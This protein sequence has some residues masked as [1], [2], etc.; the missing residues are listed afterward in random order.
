MCNEEVHGNV[1]TVGDPVHPLPHFLWHPVGVEVQVD[2][3]GKQNYLSQHVL[4]TQGEDAREGKRY[5]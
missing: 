2:L 3:R 5:L 1:F 4:M